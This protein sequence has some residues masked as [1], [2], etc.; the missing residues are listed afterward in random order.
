MALDNCPK[1]GYHGTQVY[2][3]RPTEAGRIR[4]RKCLKCPHRFATYEIDATA[5]RR[6]IRTL[7]I[8]QAL[9]QNTPDLTNIKNFLYP[10]KS[11]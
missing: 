7:R 2:D 5:Y 8:L 9:L 6:Y 10:K 3:S 11:T 1:C 4:R